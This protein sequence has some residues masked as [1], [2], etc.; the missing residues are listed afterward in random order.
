MRQ[1]RERR[2]ARLGRDA[3]DQVGEHAY[4]AAVV[5]GI[6]SRRPHAVVG[7]DTGYVDVD[8]TVLV[9]QLRDGLAGIRRPFEDGVGGL[10]LPLLDVVRRKRVPDRPSVAPRDRL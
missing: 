4:M 10:A 9:Q 5:D 1:L 2:I 7:R 6:Q 3:C 8:D